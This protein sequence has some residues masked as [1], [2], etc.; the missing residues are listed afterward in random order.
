MFE[1]SLHRRERKKIN[2][3]LRESVQLDKDEHLQPLT[4]NADS[5]LKFFYL[6]DFVYYIHELYSNF[7]LVF[8]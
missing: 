1:S 8:T 7:I 3:K 5:E 6:Q 4:W 2:P